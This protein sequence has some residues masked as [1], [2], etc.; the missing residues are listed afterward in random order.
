[1]VGF[2]DIKTIFNKAMVASQNNIGPVNLQNKHTSPGFPDLYGN[3][4]NAQLQA[5]VARGV[6]FFQPGIIPPPGTVGKL[7]DQANLVKALRG[8]AK[9]PNGAPVRVMPGGG[10]AMPDPDIAT[11]VDWINHGCPD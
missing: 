8:Q 9:L 10:P 11:I 5:A 1:M 3:F 4:S 7:G 6:P 2:N